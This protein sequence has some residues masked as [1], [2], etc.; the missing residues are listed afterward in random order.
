MRLTTPSHILLLISLGLLPLTSQAISNIEKERTA[1]DEA[2]WN[3][4]VRFSFSGKAGNNE[5]AELGLGSHIRWSNPQF[6]WLN[7][8]NRDY[9]RNNGYR[10]DDETFFHTRLIHKHQQTIAQEYFLQYEQAPFAGVKYRALQGIGLRWHSWHK[11][12]NG[13][14]QSSGDS[15]QGL[16]VFN[17]QVRELDLGRIRADQL[18]RA[19]LYS[20]WLYQFSGERAI[21]TSATLYLQPNLADTDDVKALLQA[22]IS[23]PISEQLHLQWKWQSNWDSRPPSEISKEVHETQVYLKYAF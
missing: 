19:N 20:H 15:Y 18:Y 21:S 2:G 14:K 5:E 6:K 7:W 12:N 10:T 3:G 22:Q 13:D 23:L 17:E 4:H 9:E 16:G 1:Q 11:A 8:F